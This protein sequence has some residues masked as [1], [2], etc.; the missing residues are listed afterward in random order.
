[1]IVEWRADFIGFH[2][3]CAKAAGHVAEAVAG[4]Q[5]SA[6]EHDGLAFVPDA[7]AS[8]FVTEIGALN[9]DTGCRSLPI[10]TQ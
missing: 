4:L 2:V 8:Q 5:R 6:G 1:M 9:S 3:V 10:E 7:F